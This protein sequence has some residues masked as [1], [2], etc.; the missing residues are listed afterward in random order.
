MHTT[1]RFGWG[2]V[3]VCVFGFFSSS[4]MKRLGASAEDNSSVPVQPPSADPGGNGGGSEKP[5]GPKYPYERVVCP[6]APAVGGVDACSVQHVGSAGA[7]VVV[8]GTVVQPG[9]VYEGGGVVVAADGRIACVGCDCLAQNPSLSHVACGDHVVSPGLINAHDHMGWMGSPPLVLPREGLRY[10]HRHDWRIGDP[11]ENEPAL[12]APGNASADVKTWGELRFVLGGATSINGSGIAAG[13]LRNLD[14]ERGLEGLV[15]KAV[16]YETF[17]LG[18]SNGT[19]KN[20]DC[21]YPSFDD[22]GAIQA[23]SAYTPH[24]AEGINAYARNEFSCVSGGGGAGAKD[25]LGSTWS[26]IHGVGLDAVDVALLASK[27][28]RLIWSPRSNVFLYGNTAQV[29]M[30]HKMHVPVALG[31]D[32]LPTGSMNLLRELACVRALNQRAFGGYFS[33]QDLW[34]MVTVDAALALGSESTLG[35][36]KPGKMGDLAVFART[37]PNPYASVIQANN[38]QVHLVMRGGKILMADSNITRVLEPSCDALEVCGVQK[39]VCLKRETGKS[40]VELSSGLPSSLYPLFF[41]D[42]PSNEPSCELSR[43]ESESVEG[44][45]SYP[46]EEKDVDGDGFADDADNCPR[47]FNPVRPM[48]MGEQPDAD[49][50]GL[51]DICDPCPLDANT[52]QCSVFSL[53]DRDMDGVEDARDNCAYVHNTHQENRDGDVYGDACDACPGDVNTETLG[54]PVSVYDIKKG[55]VANGTQVSLQGMVVTAVGSTGFFVQMSPY[56]RAYDASMGQAYSGVFVYTSATG[57]KP[58]VG[59]TVDVRTGEVTEFYGQKQIQRATWVV[60]QASYPAIEPVLLTD[61]SAS[62]WASYEGVLVA[63]P[64]LRVLSA[65]SSSTVSSNTVYELALDQNIQLSSLFGSV[66]FSDARTGDF[67]EAAIGVASV[68]SGKQV[69]Y[70]RIQQDIGAFKAGLVGVSSSRGFVYAGRTSSSVAERIEVVMSRPV[71]VDTFVEVVSSQP[72]WVESLG[73][74]I[75]AG[76]VQGQIVFTAYTAQ[77]TP[78]AFDVHYQG[79]HI[80]FDVVVIEPQA[81]ASLS[82]LSVSAPQ[83][84]EGSSVVITAQLSSPASENG[85]D[86]VVTSSLRGTLSASVIHIEAGLSQGTATF[87]ADAGA[88][89]GV[90]SAQLRDQTMQVALRVVAR[91]AVPMDV[92]GVRIEQRNATA[93]YTLGALVLQPGSY[94]VLSRNATRET[95]ENFWGRTLPAHVVYLNTAGALPVINGD[96]TYTLAR[97]VSDVFLPATPA[98]VVGTCG[99]REGSAGGWVQSASQQGAVEF[100][101]SQALYSASQGLYVSRVCDAM[102]NGNYVYEFVE[103]YYAGPRL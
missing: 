85:E 18:D 65:A 79:V 89:E 76:S 87:T 11:S 25:M 58:R 37:D 64:S 91:S 26:L 68:R 63:L 33:S 40:W 52:N 50:D 7:G 82:S 84:V 17:P 4:C 71:L 14:Q 75:A 8:T 9:R 47:M 70:P 93:T 10:E 32:W 86:V 31:T 100:G 56:A 95:F 57:E 54:C 13:L 53:G 2:V 66:V 80:G 16:R 61:L 90:I 42:T 21:R 22:V 29:P 15:Q 23:A 28:G 74:H 45:R 27:G 83:V 20:N 48:D 94:V 62:V 101:V 34:R 97:S 77:E 46:L 39:N 6:N 55:V 51:G 69:V 30:F 3:V 5:E 38:A 24:V 44:S 12:N 99:T 60:A 59:D 81:P 96:E 19:R 67:A 35:E 98:M 49:N 36:L 1:F 88:E 92:Q 103:L 78:V 102:G 43:G 41:C 73:A 72:S